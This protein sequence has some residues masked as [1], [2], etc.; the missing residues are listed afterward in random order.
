MIRKVLKC[1]SF[2]Q[3]GKSFIFE[4]I[5]Q[6]VKQLCMNKNGLCVIKQIVDLTKQPQNRARII[7]DI[8]ND[9]LELVSDPFGNYAIGEIVQKWDPTTLRP[10]YMQL[11]SKISELSNH[12]FGSPVIEQ[13]LKSADAEIKSLFVIEI[14]ESPRLHTLVSHQY[15][16]YVI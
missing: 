11:K 7:S 8:I 6:N 5:Y 4:E 1:P 14:S 2:N 3:E 16:N 9:L 15:G 13:C 10:I 12:K